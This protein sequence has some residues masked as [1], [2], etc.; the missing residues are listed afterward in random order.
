MAESGYP[1]VNADNWFGM[2]APVATP[3]E[4]VVKLHAALAAAA[5]AADTKERLSA[6]GVDVALSTPENFAAFLRGE[7]ARW[8][9]VIRAAGIHAD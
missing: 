4:A 8:G 1:D 5:D 7:Y 2:L 9:K 3:R 6:Q